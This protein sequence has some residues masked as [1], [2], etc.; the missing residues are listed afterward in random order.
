VPGRSRSRLAASQIE[1]DLDVKRALLSE[2]I[3]AVLAPQQIEKMKAMAADVD[4]RVD[5]RAGA[6]QR[7]DRGAA[8]GPPF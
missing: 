7:A 4:A 3:R 1:A 2:R 8:S 5:A 6:N